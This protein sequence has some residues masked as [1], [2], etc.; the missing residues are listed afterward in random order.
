MAKMFYSAEE[1]A[2]RLG[3]TEEQLK[4][5]VRGGKLREFR[6]AGT[7]NYKVDDVDAMAGPAVADIEETDDAGGSG[8][9]DIV[10]EPAEDSSVAISPSGSDVI[11]LEETDAEASAA[12]VT[13]AAA[14]AKDS[15]VVPSV[16]VNVF[17]D[18]ELD[19]QVDP[20]AQTAVTDVA[21]LGLEGTGSGSGIL[22]LTRESDDTSL[23][24]ELLD[25]IYTAEGE[26]EATVEMGDDT[27]AGLEAAI[28]AEEATEPEEAFEVEEETESETEAQPVA[29]PKRRAVVREVAVEYGPD[30]VS[31]SLTAA[32]VV[33]VVVM[34]FA[35]LGAAALVRGITPALLQTI[36]ANLWI[37]A[38]GAL[39]AGVVAAA[40]TFL[41]VRK[42]S[43]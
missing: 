22:D 21:G 1:A 38:V 4:D 27:R 30:A 13:T 17:D 9:G 29:A 16:G 14:K 33:A 23:G 43:E 12:G 26:T 8:S 3:K 18:D 34:W 41:V 7:V 35:G 32:M 6:D 10:L 25:E 40:V 36:Y 24:Q 11:S 19:E 2:E 31:T 28:P 15:T 37:Y 20:L 42:R 39:A 5:L